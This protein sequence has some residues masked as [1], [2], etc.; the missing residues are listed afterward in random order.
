MESGILLRLVGV[1]NL[2]LILSHL[3]N[4]QGREPYLCDFFKTLTLSCIQTFTDISFKLDMIETT[5]PYISIL[6]RMALA[7]I[8]GHSCLRNQK[9]PVFIF[10]EILHSVWMKFSLLP[11]PAGLLKPMLESFCRSTIQ[12]R[13]LCRRDFHIV[14]CRGTCE[15][16][17]FKLGM[18]LDT[19]KP[20]S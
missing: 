14:M 15:P 16:I 19:A 7:F 11:Q 17:C 4:F 13:E 1:V 2:T 20:Y 12:G 6:V 18:M 9:T 5:K 10:S 3:F 8:Q